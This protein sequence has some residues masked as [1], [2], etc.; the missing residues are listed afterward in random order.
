MWSSPLHLLDDVDTTA[1]PAKL[2]AGAAAR[3]AE[4]DAKRVNIR[5]TI[6]TRRNGACGLG[7][8]VHHV[9]DRRPADKK[10]EG[11]EVMRS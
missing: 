2:N 6:Y 7:L 9:H 4:K 3:K 5:H 8:E 11:L 1:T 10:Q